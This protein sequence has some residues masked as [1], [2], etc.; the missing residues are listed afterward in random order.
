MQLPAHLL[1]GHLALR[2]QNGDMFKVKRLERHPRESQYFE[3]QISETVSAKY[4][5]K[6]ENNHAMIRLIL[7]VKIVCTLTCHDI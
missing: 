7:R 3:L 5:T 1:T 6:F 2:L 4:H